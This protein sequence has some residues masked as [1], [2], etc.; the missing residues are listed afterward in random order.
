M[1]K[2]LSICFTLLILAFT[3]SA[4]AQNEKS[5]PFWKMLQQYYFAPD[6]KICSKTIDFLNSGVH[7]DE[8]FTLR[9]R[10]FYVPLFEKDAAI[11]AEFEK[12]FSK[13]ENA[14]MSELFESMLSMTTD[15]VY[16]MALPTPDVNEMLCYSY[17]ATSNTKYID[18]LLERAKG[19]EERKELDKFMI[20]ANA[21]WWLA[22]IRD[23]NILVKEYL[24]TLPTNEYAK[25][26]L[27]SRAYDLKNIQL[28]VLATQKKKGIWK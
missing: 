11:K 18:Q 6:K 24:E 21:L 25:T 15:G 1:K 23:E 3:N 20:G 14:E 26:A 8:I 27:K 4:S 17:Y 10:A 2:T 19:N 16:E 28:E 5:E 22:F 9:F 7:D 13:I 12:K